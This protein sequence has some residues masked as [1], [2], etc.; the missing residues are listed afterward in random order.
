[1]TTKEQ[2]VWKAVKELDRLGHPAKVKGW[3][4]SLYI[5]IIDQSIEEAG[6]YPTEK[7]WGLTTNVYGKG[8][9]YHYNDMESAIKF[10]I[11]LSLNGRSL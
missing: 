9:S 1:M 2:L 11:A 7:G 4:G 3:K 10:F 5:E 6:L 8:N